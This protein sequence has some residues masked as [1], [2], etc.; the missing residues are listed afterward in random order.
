M[1]HSSV[2]ARRMSLDT[3]FDS[4]EPDASFHDSYMLSVKTDFV[5]SEALI[6]LEICVGDPEAKDESLRERYREGELRLSGLYFW[7]AEPPDS[8]Q[9]LGPRRLWLE[10]GGLEELSPPEKV[11][12]LASSLPEGVAAHYFFIRDW[13]SFIY[14]AA[15]EASFMW[16]GN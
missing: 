16:S 9:N 14:F 7:V 4:S 2:E 12:K 3:I 10:Q 15:R 5:S 11:Q 1:G 6:R 8:T 13:N